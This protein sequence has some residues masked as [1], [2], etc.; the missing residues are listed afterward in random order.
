MKYVYILITAAVLVGGGFLY[1]NRSNIN[2]EIETQP[3]L[4][5]TEED[6][7]FDGDNL[8]VSGDLNKTFVIG[9]LFMFTCEVKPRD[10]TNENQIS[11]TLVCDNGA[12]GYEG[13][14]FKEDGMYVFKERVHQGPKTFRTLFEVK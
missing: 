13:A 14:V 11:K 7:S 9:N 1:A 2:E 4:S 12:G 6:F 3:F 10:I 8:I 5:L